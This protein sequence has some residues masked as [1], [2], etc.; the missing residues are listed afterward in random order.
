[1]KWI[2][3][4]ALLPLA[5]LL[6]LLVGAAILFLDPAV[7]RG[8]EVGGTA[9]VG[10]KVD[11]AK[12]RVGILDGNVR[13]NGLAVTDPAKPMTNLFEAEEIVFDVDIV[14]ALEGKVVIDTVA[15]RGLRFG[16]ARRTSGAIPRDPS[17]ADGEPSAVRKIVDDWMAQVQ[18]PPLSLSTLTRTVNVDAIS[19]ESLATLRAARAVG[20][21]ADTARDR[22][23]SGIRAL[24][25]RPT[26]DSAEA[27]ANRLRNANLRT[28]G[29]AGARQAATDVRRALRDL[30]ALND[31]LKAFEQ[32]SRRDV[33]SL[34][35]RVEAIGRARAT[36][37]AYA[38][39]LLRLP[40]FEIPAIGPQ[41]FSGLLAE[42]VGEVMYWVNMAE[43]YIP[44]GIQ[45]QM[46]KGP[47]RVRASGTTVL[48]PKEKVYP[49]FLARLAEL[50]LAIGGEGASAGEYEA[51]LVGV[52][53][54]PAVYGAPTRFVVSRAAGKVGPR[55][56][57]ISGSLDHRGTPVRDSLTARL[58]GFP[59][60]TM[61][62]A[63]LGAAVDLGNGTSELQLAREGD[64]LAGTWLWRSTAV[65]WARDTTSA[66]R[67]STVAMRLVEDALWNAI[68]RID[69]VEIEARFSGSVTKPQLAVRTNI[70]EAV[71]GALK[72]QLG[73]EVRRAEQQVRAKVDALVEEKA[74]EAR[75][76]A[77]EVRTQ[78][79]TRLAEERAKLEAQQ[80]ALEARLRELVRIPGI[81]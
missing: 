81:G 45:R 3:W 79:E 41:L 15:A 44:P 39:G 51:R 75:A 29:I 69:A 42:K 24:D 72:A 34:T 23:T 14:P 46:Q 57:R 47:D 56:A 16:T 62:L 78:A 67:A 13:L 25:P 2:R 70:A 17:A 60:P 1:M 53:S 68:S 26:I 6:L 65:K 21:F 31:K 63:G 9:A 50:S 28:L 8:V 59:L 58:S 66:P 54:Q 37:Y 35:D 36:D 40:T 4:K 18:V 38:R 55:D 12:A 32:T 74:R 43:Q 61:P 64:R 5:V 76:K 30:D 77:D 11:L 48:F 27:L 52:T 73:E 20:T 7:R 10:A 49:T 80:A 33:D 19:A 22:F 71:A